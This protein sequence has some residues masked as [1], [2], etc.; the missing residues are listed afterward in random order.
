MKLQK[1]LSRKVGK[2]E[3]P[4]Y[5]ITIPPKL[6]EEL[7]WKKGVEVEASK[8]GDKLLLEPVVAQTRR[9]LHPHK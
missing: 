7:G 3:Y 5:V 9:K 2:T 6:I 4:K 1:Q 8:K